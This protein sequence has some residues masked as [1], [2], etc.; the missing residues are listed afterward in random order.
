MGQMGYLPR[1]ICCL[2]DTPS[3]RWCGLCAMLHVLTYLHKPAVLCCAVLCCAVL[4]R[5]V[6]PRAGPPAVQDPVGDPLQECRFGH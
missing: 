1:C 6:P 4:C 3:I 2:A 5:A